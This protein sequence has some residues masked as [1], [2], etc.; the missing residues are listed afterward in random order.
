MNKPNI[1]LKSGRV[2]THLP[3]PNG[4]TDAN[5]ADGGTMS[6]DE[7]EEY[8]AIVVKRSATRIR[9]VERESAMRSLGLMK[10]KGALGGTYWE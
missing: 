2:V 3:M 4:A 6:H 8:C 5:M 1:T 10:V 7:W 9:R